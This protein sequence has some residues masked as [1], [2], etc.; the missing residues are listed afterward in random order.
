MTVDCAVGVELEGQNSI[1]C[2]QASVT[3]RLNTQNTRD[4]EFAFLAWPR[5]KSGNGQPVEVCNIDQLLE[6]AASM[7]LLLFNRRNTVMG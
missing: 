4:R 7:L 5:S 3:M 1:R 2:N 6:A